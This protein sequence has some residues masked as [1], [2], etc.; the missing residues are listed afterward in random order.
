VLDRSARALAKLVG[1][2]AADRLEPGLRGDLGD[3]CAHSPQ[4]DDSHPAN[5]ERDANWKNPR[6]SRV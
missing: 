4:T 5:H 3:P 1:H 2:L 6:P